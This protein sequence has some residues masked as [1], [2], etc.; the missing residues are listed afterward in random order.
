M[1]YRKL[2]AKRI[3]RIKNSSFIFPNF[4]LRIPIAIKFASLNM[5]WRTDFLL[6]YIG[7]QI[8]ICFDA[9]LLV[10]FIVH[11][12]LHVSTQ[13]K[14]YQHFLHFIFESKGNELFRLDMLQAMDSLGSIRS[15]LSFQ[16]VFSKI[17]SI[18]SISSD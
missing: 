8:Y 16:I 17:K 15:S 2:S 10:Y 1:L 12:T 7:F 6:C 5:L 13:N 4:L 11:F 3:A 9:L 14:D 18:E